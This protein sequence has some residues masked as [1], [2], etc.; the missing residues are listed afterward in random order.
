[1][2]WAV[3]ENFDKLPEDVKNLLNRLQDQLQCVIENLSRGTSQN[4]I[5]AIEVISNARSKIDK[6]FAFSVLGSLSRDENEE[7][8][9]KAEKLEWTLFLG[10]ENE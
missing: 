6:N 4:K 7:V 8:G 3:A 10:I 5:R 2:S 9:M 1:M